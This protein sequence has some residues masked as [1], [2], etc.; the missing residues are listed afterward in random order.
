[1]SSFLAVRVSTERC[2]QTCGSALSQD[3]IGGEIVDRDRDHERHF[4]A[5]R[6]RSLHR[7]KT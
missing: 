7:S 5:Y 1:M 3:T 6:S 2:Q 4:D